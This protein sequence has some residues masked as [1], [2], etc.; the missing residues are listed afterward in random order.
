MKKQTIILLITVFIL[1][2]C[3]KNEAIDEKPIYNAPSSSVLEHIHDSEFCCSP[4]GNN[5]IFNSNF[6]GVAITKE[7]PT[8]VN[9]P[10]A[11]ISVPIISYDNETGILYYVK[12]GGRYGNERDNFLYSYKDGESEL[13]VEMPV[14]YII[15]YNSAIYFT[16]NEDIM[17]LYG[18]FPPRPEGR[19]YKYNIVNKTV[20]LLVNENVYNLMLCENYIYYTTSFSLDG[21]GYLTED[22]YQHFRIPTDGGE[23]E[24]IGDFRP[25][26]FG[27]YQVK[28]IFNKEEGLFSLE[29]VSEKNRT[30]IA[31]NFNSFIDRDYCIAGNTLWFKEW[32]TSPTSLISID[33]SNG[34]KK[35]YKHDNA[36]EINSFAVLEDELYMI[37]SYNRKKM[38]LKYDWKKEEFIE[39]N[40]VNNTGYEY[41]L[42]DGNYI[43]MVTLNSNSQNMNDWTYHLTRLLPLGNG[44]YETEVIF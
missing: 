34:E 14:N 26:F 22:S 4:T 35:D 10:F 17:A 23:P 29:L 9:S 21:A 28:E 41:I 32:R 24:H 11:N 8:L 16:S 12:Y 33:L 5:G 36:A 1:S 40:P 27:E 42:T 25:F 3:G 18:L 37:A 43:Y 20:E 39:I 30:I 44:K 15:Y 38:L 6:K 2:G 19:L 13:L 7:S 31:K